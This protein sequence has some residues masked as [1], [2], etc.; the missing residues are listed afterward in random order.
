LG[1][2]KDNLFDDVRFDFVTQENPNTD[3][4]E[5]IKQ[6]PYTFVDTHKL[7]IVDGMN[8]ATK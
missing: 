2:D 1:A 8:F 5:K 6:L 3:F 7:A 4:N